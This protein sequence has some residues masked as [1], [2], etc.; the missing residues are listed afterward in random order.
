MREYFILKAFCCMFFFSCRVTLCDGSASIPRKKKAIWR[1][2]NFSTD[3]IAQENKISPLQFNDI[4]PH[5]M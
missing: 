5:Y 2:N 4:E 1:S 3:N